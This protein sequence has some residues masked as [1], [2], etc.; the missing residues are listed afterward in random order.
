MTRNGRNMANSYFCDL[1]CSPVF[2]TFCNFVAN[3]TADLKLDTSL[4]R[5]MNI[6]YCNTVC[7]VSRPGKQ[8][9]KSFCLKINI[10]T[11]NTNLNFENWCNGEVSESAKIWLSKS[12]FYIR[13]HS[14]LFNFLSL[15]NTN[16]GAHFC[17]WHFLITSISKLLYY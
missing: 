16:L 1:F 4:T 12:I 17:C 10:P 7:G 11:E 14:N 5:L 9:W 6:G 13:N 8:N 15:N 2:T 3:C